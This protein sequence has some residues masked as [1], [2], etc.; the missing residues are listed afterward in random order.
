VYALNVVVFDQDFE[1]TTYVALSH[2]LDF[3]ADPLS[4]AREFP[5]FESIAAAG[6]GL[7]VSGEGAALSRHEI[8][9]ALDWRDGPK[10][11][12][13]DYGIMDAGFWD[14]F[15]LDD[16]TAYATADTTSRVVWD[17]VAFVI[18]DFLTD[19]RIPSEPEGGLELDAAFNRTS[20]IPKNGPV[21]RPFYYRDADWF[22]FSD[23]SWI[24]IYDPVTHEERAV[25]DVPCPALENAT[26]DE[27]GNT[28]FST[29]NVRP[30]RYLYGLAPEACFARVTAD[31]RLDTQ[32]APNVRDWTG[33][34][35]PMVMRYLEGG[36]AVASFLDVDAIE[37]DWSGPVDDAVRE[38]IEL[39]SHFRLWLLD[40]DAETATEVDGVIPMDGQFHGR[41]VDGRHFVYLP[42]DG[43]TRTRI[44]EILPEQGTAVEHEDVPG[45]VYDLVK[46]R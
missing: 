44:Y 40:F 9:D 41:T 23:R 36:K 6:G 21:L 37:A 17:P 7:I 19:S 1:A 14:Q 46:V 11:S 34:R 26:E 8:T 16:R 29:W 27:A 22:E 33:G 39:G 25:L 20:W 32:F 24:A 15:F 42:Y 3:G 35:P 30:T 31:G 13:A 2:T 4:D 43:Y 18:G 28:Y 38:E 12:F 45:W 10:L 5:G